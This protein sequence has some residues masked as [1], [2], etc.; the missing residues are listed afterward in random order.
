MQD[1]PRGDRGRGAHFIQCHT[2]IT[3][4]TESYSLKRMGNVDESL[5]FCTFFT[6]EDL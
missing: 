6:F 1:Y 5:F 4:I 2:E 3:E